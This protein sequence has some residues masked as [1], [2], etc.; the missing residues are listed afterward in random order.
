MI[1]TIL[2]LDPKWMQ[3]LAA[4]VRAPHEKYSS[5]L[6]ESQDSLLECLITCIYRDI[7]TTASVCTKVFP[8]FFS[9]RIVMI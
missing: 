7:D 4:A 8:I 9:L 5:Q 2:I 3:Q 6:Q 1:A